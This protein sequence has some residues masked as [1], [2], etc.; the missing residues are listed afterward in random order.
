MINTNLKS[1]LASMSSGEIRQL[2]AE[3]KRYAA[4]S[5]IVDSLKRAL[6]SGHLLEFLLEDDDRILVDK[7]IKVEPAGENE[8]Y[9]FFTAFNTNDD[10]ILRVLIDTSEEWMLNS[11]NPFYNFKYGVPTC[12][13]V[14]DEPVSESIDALRVSVCK[15]QRAV[16]NEPSET[17]IERETTDLLNNIISTCKSNECGYDTSCQCDDEESCQRCECCCEECNK[18][19]KEDKA[20][21]EQLEDAFVKIEKWLNA[22]NRRA[23]LDISRSYTFEDEYSSTK[24]H[25]NF[26]L[27]F[28][29]MTYKSKEKIA[30]FKEAVNNDSRYTVSVTEF[31]NGSVSWDT[32]RKSLVIAN[33]DKTYTIRICF[34][35]GANVIDPDNGPFKQ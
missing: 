32:N 34:M 19:D 13:F 2:L 17:V 21:F 26:N 22:D 24:R 6:N 14:G 15:F 12:L 29:S 27:V 20:V 11:S 28:S 18:C 1:L 33:E 25:N 30:T 35:E 23:I 10:I 5:V 4:S 3:I 8:V 7:F 16:Y 9:V 31:I